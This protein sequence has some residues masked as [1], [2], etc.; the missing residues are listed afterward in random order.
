VHV[1][2]AALDPL[3]TAAADWTARKPNFRL[4]PPTT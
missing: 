2:A 1:P 3:R 4:L